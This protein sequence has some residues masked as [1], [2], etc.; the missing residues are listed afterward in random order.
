MLPLAPRL[1]V[2]SCVAIFV[3]GA[4]HA[5]QAS[6]GWSGLVGGAVCDELASAYDRQAGPEGGFL[7]PGAFFTPATV[8]P[9]G[10]I[11][12][13]AR[14][15]GLDR[16]Q[17]VLVA[18]ETG[19]HAIAMG[20]GLGLGSGVPGPPVGDPSPIG[21]RFSGFPAVAE[22]P[23]PPWGS[24]HATLVG[25]AFAP[26]TN[27]EG[28][29]L[30]LADVQGGSSPRGL[31][32]YRAATQTIVKVAALGDPSPA[33]G[34]LQ[35]ISVGSL[36]D[37]GV[38]VFLAIG[39]TPGDEQILRWDDGVLSKVARVGDPAPTPGETYGS[40]GGHEGFG[41]PDG[42]YLPL[43]FLP[44]VNNHGAVAFT[45]WTTVP[46]SLQGAVVVRDARA[47]WQA[48][49]G[50]PAPGGGTL[51][52]FSDVIL[53]DAGDIAFFNW[54]DPFGSLQA[55]WIVGRPGSWRR[56]IAWDDVLSGGRRVVVLATSHNP[57]SPL[58]SDGDLVVWANTRVGAVEHDVL[59]LCR[60]DGSQEVIRG[61]GDPTLLGGVSE[62][63]APW[64]SI[65][66]AGQVSFDCGI[67]GAGNGANSGHF[68]LTL[69]PIVRSYCSPGT[70][71]HD[72]TG[73]LTAS[74]IPSAS[75][76]SGFTITASGVD[77]QELVAFFYGVRGRTAI[78]WWNGSGELC[79]VLPLQRARLQLSGGTAGACDG[80]TS[81]DLNT[82]FA[83][84]PDAL[85]QPVFA[86]QAINVQAWVRNP[87]SAGMSTLTD[88][89]ELWLAP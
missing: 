82:Y 68:L 23:M 74:G 40:F 56:A 65:N 69:C 21:G 80:S 9:V 84:H 53:N 14:I 88:A 34:S 11:A 1:L 29:V 45:V 62:Q 51:G 20:S 5:R 6:G 64:P 12:F 87:G 43:G 50:D 49:W 59:V 79:V 47:T 41:C 89:L 3:S 8:G 81:L 31:F 66:S 57:M 67:R 63:S 86:G 71:T 13:Y 30:F 54:I 61:D 32:L 27:S 77:G 52:P 73:T 37:A 44:D 48:Q 38:A 75:A 60:A 4:A 36:N 25:Y 15:D 2:I 24:E 85:G 33:G 28:D 18:D 55:A 70:S 42:T 72:C 83:T 35:A 78:P 22:A 39:S 10:R 16:N 46:G 26:A 58:S 7:H 19:L 76:T 17:G